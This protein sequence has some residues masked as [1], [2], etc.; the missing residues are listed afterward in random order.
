MNGDAD[1]QGGTWLDVKLSVPPAR[2]SHDSHSFYC[3]ADFVLYDLL[4]L[5]VA[6]NASGKPIHKL[7]ST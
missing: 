7:Q 1:E 3:L 2:R 5:I 6:L 4:Q